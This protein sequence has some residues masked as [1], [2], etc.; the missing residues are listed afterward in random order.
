MKK[1]ILLLVTLAPFAVS[2]QNI[3]KPQFP[4]GEAELNIFIRANIK[5]D[6]N[7]LTLAKNKY[8]MLTCIIDTTGVMHGIEAVYSQIM[9]T[10]RND[11]N[12]E[13]KR[14]LMLVAK[15]YVWTPAET[16][17]KKV[18]AEQ[19]I[20][21]SFDVDGDV[22]AKI[23]GSINGKAE[24]ASADLFKLQMP[25]KPENSNNKAGTGGSDVKE[26]ES[27][28]EERN[29][30]EIEWV[31]MEEVEYDEPI[32]EQ[33]ELVE[34]EMEE[35]EEV[36]MV[37]QLVEEEEEVD[38]VYMVDVMP[39]PVTEPE[40][41]VVVEKMPEFPGGYEALKKFI[42]AN[43]KMPAEA[44]TNGA[45]GKVMVQFTVDE[46]G[47][48]KDIKWLNDRVGYGCADEALRVINLMAAKYTWIPGEQ[49]GK[50]VPVRM[51][52]PVEFKTN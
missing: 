45:E 17:G 15:K 41:F 25:Q 18:E 34:D 46:M 32:I 49:R 19:V 37:I 33:E 3:T 28:D 39:E 26:E 44:I 14:V 8:T 52:C 40:V 47:K 43:I 13:L 11:I 7:Y 22:T 10:G 50:K 6:E 48:V 4:G 9:S 36:E 23:G 27:Q 29:V 16:N 24:V 30:E 35:D 12:T 2:A 42:A 31:E 21:F 51:I 20:T 1:L 38:E 5:I